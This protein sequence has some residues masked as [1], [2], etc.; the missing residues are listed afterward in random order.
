MPEEIK[1]HW[2]DYSE[3]VTE[4]LTD[5]KMLIAI[6]E[7]MVEKQG[8]LSFPITIEVHP[9]ATGGKAIW[10]DNYDVGQYDD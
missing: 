6:V 4:D 5:L 8:R 1:V 2:K 7:E 3:H 10:L 9:T